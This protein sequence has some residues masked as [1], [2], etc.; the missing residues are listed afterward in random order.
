MGKKS[1]R[2]KKEKRYRTLEERRTELNRLR[3]KIDSLGMGEG[4]PEIERLFRDMETFEKT[5]ETIC[6]D[7][8][9]LGFHR[10]LCYSFSNLYHKEL[11]VQLPYED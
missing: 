3:V 6:Q 2:P 10:R 8:P 1:R 7:V 9:L 11:V 5:G 4:I